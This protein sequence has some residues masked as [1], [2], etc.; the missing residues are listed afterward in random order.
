MPNYFETLTPQQNSNIAFIVKRMKE[1]GITNLF[2]QAGIL[3]VVSKESSFV[4]RSELGYGATSNARIRQIFGSRVGKL[5]E[6]ELTA[7]KV[8]DEA[9]FNLIYGLV[10][11]GQTETEGYKYRGRG[12]NQITFKENYKK[13]GDQIGVDL[14]SFPDKLNELPVATDCLIQ[15]FLNAFKSMPKTIFVQYGVHDINSFQNG[16]DSVRILY[17]ANSGWGT[18]KAT[19][20][21]DATGGRAKAESRF[22]GFYNIVI[23]QS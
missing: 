1:K 17:H 5:S 4:P 13:V 21:A 7:T 6:D 8:K 10:K 22:D 3:S 15:F 20:D 11:F 14:V 18:S 23:K 19:L 12:L 16:K 9:F 2:A